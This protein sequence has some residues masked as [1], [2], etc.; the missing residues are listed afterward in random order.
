MTYRLFS[1]AFAAMLVLT[2]ASADARMIDTKNICSPSFAV[3]DFQPIN[4]GIVGPA[5]ADVYYDKLSCELAGPHCRHERLPPGGQVLLGRRWRDFVCAYLPRRRNSIGGWVKANEVIVQPFDRNPPLRAWL[6]YWSG[7]AV[8]ADDPYVRFVLRRGVLM[9]KGESWTRP[10]EDHI[11]ALNEVVTRKGY[12]AYDEP[13][14]VTFWLIG[15][16]LV[17]DD[18]D[19]PCGGSGA[20]FYGVYMKIT[21]NNQ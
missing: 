12:I 19:N 15:Q 3:G 6:G 13:C 11:G 4:A 17:A 5:G 10:P 21:R 2:G 16:F 8:P 7:D 20:S 9:V 18:H 1:I 14:K